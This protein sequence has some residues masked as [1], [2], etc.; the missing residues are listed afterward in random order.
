MIAEIAPD[1]LCLGPHGRTQTNIYFVRSGSSWALVDT[2]WAGDEPRILEAAAERFG[3][4][5]RPAAI[6]LTHDHPDHGGA[7]KGLARRW[8]CPVWMHPLEMPIALGD[9]AAMER[10]AGPLDRWVILPIMRAIGRNR[11][12]AAIAR[13]SLVGTAG[14]F[15]PSG[16]VPGLPDWECVPTPGHTPGHIS[17]F[18][19]HDRVLI[20]GDALVTLRVNSPSGFLLGSAGLSAPPR[21]T[22]WDWKGALASIEALARLEPNTIA[23]GH[24]RPLSGPDTAGSLSAFA[25]RLVGRPN[26]AAR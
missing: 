12:E 4:A 23:G 24:G 16:A 6:L 3:P 22:S 15:D 18:R 25:E 14:A 2:G 9:F 1:V 5:F 20:S 10:F 11:R 21:Y 26:G 13:S 19:R 17:L 8:E 7:A